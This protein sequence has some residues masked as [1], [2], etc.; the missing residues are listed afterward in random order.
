MVEANLRWVVSLAKRYQGHG[1]ALADLVQLGNLGLL[2]AVERFDE[3]RGF[4]FTTYATWWIRVSITRGLAETGRAIR[5]PDHV[6]RTAWQLPDIER[7]LEVRLHRAASSAELADSLGVTVPQLEALRALPEVTRTL[8]QPFDEGSA[9]RPVDLVAS[10]E[11]SP[12]EA[13]A[14]TELPRELDRL[15]TPLDNRERLAL[16]LRYGL[17]G[18]KPQS[19][20]A[21]ARQ[22]DVTRERARQI[23]HTALDKLHHPSSRDAWERA[24]NYLHETG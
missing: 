18:R 8:D 6:S 12:F 7:E 17:D 9:L 1:L 22:L 14:A 13:V 11:P 3:R 23:Q 16:L 20:E 15:L 5:L 21:V 10:G 4:R 19:L 2:E 24:K